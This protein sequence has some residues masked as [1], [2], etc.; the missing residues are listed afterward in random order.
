M[1]CVHYHP[2]LDTGQISS[3]RNDSD[4]YSWFFGFKSLQRHLQSDRNVLGSSSLSPGI[5]RVSALKYQGCLLL[6]RFH[7][8]IQPQQTI[9]HH[10]IAFN[11]RTVCICTLSLEPLQSVVFFF[12][13]T[14]SVTAW[15][16]EMVFT[17]NFKDMFHM[18]SRRS[19]GRY[20]SLADSDHGVFFFTWFQ[21]LV[22]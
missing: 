14:Q 12:F 7:F 9:R 1:F 19:L 17:W 20:N 21:E 18:I 5:V 13:K 16:I 4:V 22:L 3:S 6:H 10:K 2:S 11:H 8:I 15:V